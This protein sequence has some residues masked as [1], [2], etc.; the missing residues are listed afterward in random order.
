LE[1]KDVQ[2]KELQKSSAAMKQRD[3]DLIRDIEAK[4]KMIE[5]QAKR[6]P[7]RE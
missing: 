7:M 1:E 2:F 3:D 5:D 4:D 6:Q